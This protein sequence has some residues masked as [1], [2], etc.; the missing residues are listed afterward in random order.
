MKWFGQG[1][2]WSCLK[3]LGL[4]HVLQVDTL[5]SGGSGMCMKQGLGYGLVTGKSEVVG[6]VSRVYTLPALH[7]W[8]RLHL[9]L[10]D[11]YSGCGI[12]QFT[13][14]CRGWS[15]ITLG[16]GLLLCTLCI[17]GILLLVHEVLSRCTS[18]SWSKVNEPGTPCHPE[19]LY[20]YTHSGVNVDLHTSYLC[21]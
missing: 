14:S 7:A 9:V 1:Y 20:R 21:I 5:I 2:V 12:W 3:Q 11:L 18:H 10:R 4:G 13:Q 16:C 8:N 6:V 19:N 15:T 17:P